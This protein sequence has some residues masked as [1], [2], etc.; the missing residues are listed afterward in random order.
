MNRC[1]APSWAPHERI[2][3]LRTVRTCKN[4]RVPTLEPS[5]ALSTC[6]TALRELMTYAYEDRYG[7]AWLDRVTKPKQREAWAERAHVEADTR[8]PR[9]VA[10]VPNV[11]LSYANF[12]DLLGIVEKERNWEPLAGALGKRAEVL[13]LLQRFEKLRN[14]IG[15]SRPLI[16]FEQELMSGIA[17]Q[18]RN[19]VTLF[20]SEQDDAGDIYPRIESITDPFGR[21][22]EVTV[23]DELTY[24]FIRDPKITL[25]PGDVVAFTCIGVDPQGRDLAWEMRPANYE[26]RVSQVGSSGAPTT[27]V[28][29][30]QDGDVA[31]KR[32]IEIRMQAHMAKYRRYGSFDHRAY[33]TFRVR[34]PA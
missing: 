17:G 24:R 28:W 31:E 11:G 20:M 18:I 1:G 3:G 12:Y 22:F 34:P 32:H 13:P 23:V 19:Q 25:R 8:V 33:F 5:V 4:A 21:R 16:P 9:G 6:E 30:V 2:Q 15:H 29:V 7:N 14:T 26:S 27:V 10:Q